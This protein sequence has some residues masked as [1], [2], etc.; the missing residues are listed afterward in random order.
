MTGSIRHRTSSP[1]AT[2]RGRRSALVP[3]ALALFL[4]APA[5]ACAPG[6][7]SPDPVVFGLVDSRNHAP[8]E[9]A[10][11]FSPGELWVERSDVRGRVALEPE[12]A[13]G[14]ATVHA[15]AYRPRRLSPAE[16]TGDVELVYDS[17]L[18]NPVEAALAF[19]RADTLRGAYGPYRANNDLLTYDLDVAVDVEEELLRGANRIRFRMLEDD[20]RI[21]LDLFDNLDIEAITLQERPLTFTREHNAVFVD[22][23]DT[24]RAGE[25]YAIEVR[26]AGHPRRTGRFGGFVF[27]TDSLG[28][29]WIFTANQGTGAS[30]WWPNKDQ[31]PDEVD[32]M[33][34][35]VTV[36]TGLVDVSNGRLVGR[37]DLENGTTRFDWKIH[38]PINNYSVSLNIGKYEHFADSLS[39]LTLDFYALPYHLDEARRQFAQAKPM[40][41]CYQR[42]FGDY[43]F[44]KDGYKLVEVPYSGM[45]HQSAVTYGNRFENGYL[46]RDWTGVGISP[47]FDFIIIH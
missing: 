23:P 10:L 20:D 40:L 19:T 30:L 5:R 39:G 12:E 18:A 46:G 3:A 45:E 38:Y 35:S 26:Y 1:G 37:E 13:A 6:P 33:T 15:K 31:Q 21:Q 4:V 16:L 29:P 32:S 42:Y 9:G 24:L 28:N 36:P 47:R 2:A 17:A 14:G 8:I 25:T 11:V 44:P 7:A 43:P 34:L 41:R 27:S 22:F